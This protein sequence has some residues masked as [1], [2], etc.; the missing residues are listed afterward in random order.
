MSGKES[1]RNTRKP[2]S[3]HN[4]RSS[5][6]PGRTFE[7]KTAG[8]KIIGRYILISTL[9][10]LFAGVIAL[11][12]F[13]TT[14]VRAEDWRNKANAEL[15]RRD[16][17]FPDRG[18]I[19]AADGSVLATNLINYNIRIDFTTP[20]FN[21]NWL[22]ESLDSLCD[23]LA[24][25]HPERT[26]KLWKEYIESALNKEKK[27]RSFKLLG[28]LT[29][30]EALAVQNYP[31]FRRTSNR[32]KT[33]FVID[34]E[35]VRSYPFGEMAR[36][37]IG[38]VVQKGKSRKV[39][40]ASGLELALDTL[41][42]GKLG[43]Y[44]RIP[45][46]HGMTNWRD[47]P[48]EPGKTLTTTI[49]VGIQDIVEHE[50][51]DMLEASEAEWGTVVLMDV[52]TGDIKAISNLGRTTD[53]RYVETLNHAVQR[54]EPG[55]VIKTV[56]MVIAL[57]DGLTTNPDNDFYSLGGAYVFGSGN[58]IKDTHSPASLPVG[59]FLEYSSNIGMTKLV[60]Q[61]F[62]KDPSK[63]HDRVEQLGF[64]DRFNT[65]IA[66]EEP[67]L[68][69]HLKNDVGGVTNLG[70]QTF[71]Y[72]T[73][74]SP[75]YMCAFY[76]AVAN[77]GKFVRPRL[78]TK[79]HSADGDSTID[80]SYVRDQM[81][82]PQTA[83]T[84]REMLHRVVY[85]T[86][87]TAKILRDDVVDIA[88][89]T[90]TS[91]IARE[92][93]PED[94]AKY[95][96]NPKDPTIK[97]VSGYLDGVYRYSFCGFFPFKD[98]KYTCMVMIS[99]PNGEYRSAPKCSGRLCLN[100]AKR[101]YSKGLLGDGPSL[102]VTQEGPKDKSPIVYATTNS[103]RDNI[104]VPMLG[105]SSAKRIQTPVKTAD[106]RIPSVKGLGLRE[107]LVVL[108]QAGYNVSFEGEGSVLSQIPI[109][110]TAAGPGSQVRLVLTKS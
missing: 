14:V 20:K 93:S 48:E 41:L 42:F 99:R 86:G 39:T 56:G 96:I 22:K 6:K 103:S 66:G 110:G 83:A 57:E 106:G 44:K 59:R 95:K 76:N 30:E 21:E 82:S 109:A 34:P 50:L 73:Q 5:V 77:N 45:L 32:N 53:G 35:K 47:I 88:G 72:N 62:R 92:M 55:S 102:P 40:G 100:I 79:I 84:V 49:D 28:G 85:G 10:V 18:E 11:N 36:R 29:H 9:I 51:A 101:L 107:A 1:L 7:N 43:F 27:S 61:H 81:C 71:G 17:I 3:R 37:S 67:P 31:F 33:G 19:L 104:L 74:V 52:E 46:T 68:F 70:R 87:G 24:V 80:V 4:G 98:P 69:P 65:G 2:S 13:Q 25:H 26:A 38:R 105:A 78:V 54:Y 12:L 97:R 60:A 75:L 91:R 15:S 89:K 16:T 8:R 58:P 108:E 90:G 23:T 94:L 64:F 63:Y